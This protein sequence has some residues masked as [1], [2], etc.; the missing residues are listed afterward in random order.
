[1]GG[2]D[3]V[4]PSAGRLEPP[5]PGRKGGRRLRSR[6]GEAEAAPYKAPPSTGA[7]PASCRFPGLESR[8]KFGASRGSEC[9][10]SRR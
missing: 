3:P 10:N 9:E 6:E 5:C 4:R 2:A 1:M 7:A 8:G